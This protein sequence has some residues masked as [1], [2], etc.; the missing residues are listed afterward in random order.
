MPWRFRT[1]PITCI[2]HWAFY[3]FAGPPEHIVALVGPCSR[4]AALA[5]PL[6]AG[7]VA[8][9]PRMPL[10]WAV[11]PEIYGRGAYAPFN[12]Y[13]PGFGSGADFGWDASLGLSA[14]SFPHLASLPAGAREVSTPAVWANRA[15]QRTEAVRPGLPGERQG[16]NGAGTPPLLPSANAPHPVPEPSA[17]LIALWA[18][19][20]LA[21]RRANFR[22]AQRGG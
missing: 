3:P 21:V 12:D 18:L 2:R 19:A 15:P 22:N 5:W 10:P 17:V 1:D 16:S 13:A 11:Q 7:P 20:V 6:L 4:A 8:A 14:G 9:S